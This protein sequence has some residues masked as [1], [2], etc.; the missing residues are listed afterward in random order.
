M[1]RIGVESMPISRAGTTS[2]AYLMHAAK[3]D[4]AAAMAVAK[5]KRPI[6]DPFDTLVQ[7]L[8]SVELA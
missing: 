8:V 7:F 6:I 5:E 1:H 4:M 2:I 3:L